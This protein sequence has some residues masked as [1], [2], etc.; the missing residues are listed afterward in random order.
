MKKFTTILLLI[1]LVFSFAACSKSTDENFDESSSL[2]GAENDTNITFEEFDKPYSETT[3]TNITE[4]NTVVWEGVEYKVNPVLNSSRDID[5]ADHSE[6]D[7]IM[8]VEFGWNYTNDNGEGYQSILGMFYNSSLSQ[9][10]SSSVIC[11]SFCEFNET[12]GTTKWSYFDQN[13]ALIYYT[14]DYVV[15]DKDDMQ[16][17]NRNL[18]GTYSD[19]N[20]NNFDITTLDPSL[21][22]IDI[23]NWKKFKL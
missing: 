3:K 15:Y 23:F 20:G 4:F 8:Y 10:S 2:F 14:L 6:K 12:D 19:L 16:I 17:G 7:G 5:Y 9:D 1:L 13:N 21:K 11:S 22:V 18:D